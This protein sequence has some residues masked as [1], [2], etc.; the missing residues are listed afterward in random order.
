VLIEV[1]DTGCGIDES[2]IPQLFTPFFTKKENKK[3]TGI[4]LTICKRIIETHGG[5]IAVHSRKGFGTKFAITI[6]VQ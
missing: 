6:P 2:D 5:T 1:E 3:G 4:G